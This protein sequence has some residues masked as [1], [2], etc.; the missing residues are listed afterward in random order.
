MTHPQTLVLSSA[1]TLFGVALLFV[2]V[3]EGER[4]LF[5]RPLQTPNALL[6]LWGLMLM[7]GGAVGWLRVALTRRPFG[8][9]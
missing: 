4:A 8:S 3:Q 6:I 2:G 7:A 5:S 9:R 1:A